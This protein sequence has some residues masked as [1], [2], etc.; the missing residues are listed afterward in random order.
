MY[1]DFVTSTDGARLLGT[2]DA[3]NFPSFNFLGSTSIISFMNLGSTTLS[4]NLALANAAGVAVANVAFQ[5]PSMGTY[6]RTVASLFPAQA[7]GFNSNGYWI[8][9]NSVATGSKIIGTTLTPN[10]GKDNVVANAASVSFASGVFPHVVGGQ[11]GATIYDSVLT[12]TNFQASVVTTLT[13]RQNSGAVLTAQ[14]TIPQIGVLRTS[15]TSLFGVPTV[16]GWLQVDG[17]TGA[18]LAGF[19]SYTDTGSGGS[20]AVEMQSTTGSD[21][22]LIFGHIANVSPW[23][24]GISLA[25]PSTTTGAQVEVYAFDSAGKLIAGPA[26]WATASFTLAPLT[27]RAFLIDEVLPG[28]QSRQSDGGYVYIRTLNG[29]QIHGIELFFLRSG[30]VYSNVPA[31]RLA[32]LGLVYTPTTVTVDGSG[33]TGSGTV[34]M[35]QAFIG[36]SSNRVLTSVQACAAITLNTQVNNTTGR[37][38]SVTREYRATGPNGYKLYVAS[39]AREQASG[40]SSAF[41]PLTVPCDAPAGTYSFTAAVDYN[42]TFSAASGTSTITASSGGSG[43][44][45]GT[46]GTTGGTGGCTPSETTICVLASDYDTAPMMETVAACFDTYTQTSTISAIHFLAQGGAPLSGYTWSLASGSTLPAGTA[47]EPL[48]GVFKGTGGKVFAGT[49]TIQASDGSRTGSRTFS[50]TVVTRNSDVFAANF[51]GPCGV[52]AF[53][54]PQSRNILLPNAPQGRGY[55]ASLQAILGRPGNL[56][57]TV[58][59]GTLPGG[60]TLDRS[61]GVLRGTPLSSASG[62]TFRFQIAITT[63]NPGTAG[64]I[65]SCSGFGCPTYA[66][67]VP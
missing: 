54:Q 56:T 62:T 38:V 24:T 22:S 57:W 55:G 46:G 30:R 29:V 10:P 19:V 12:L 6:Q 64:P 49:F 37:T 51:S 25:N 47:L 61:S 11:I 60:M 27:K 35:E 23:W 59:S 44:T 32:R 48:T 41:V 65:A 4:G 5:L 3:I 39:F 14:R 17:G 8:G 2:A 66:I 36:D 9:F 34:T 67:T 50:L 7:A 16:D 18:A 26:Q 45:G 58:A 42:G 40:R 63:S 43:G 21:T 28:M 31:I 20:T 52:A 13:L 33:T 15:I 53:Q 1:G